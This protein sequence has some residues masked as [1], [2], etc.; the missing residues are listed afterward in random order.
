MKEGRKT[1]Y[2]WLIVLYGA[3][4]MS[5]LHYTCFNSF[6]LFV[7]PV[8]EGL[9]IS[10][11]AFSLTMTVGSIASVIASPLTGD[12]LAYKNVKKY[13]FFGILI[14]G[15]SVFLEGFASSVYQLYFLTLVL[16]LASNFALALPF[17]IL[18]L[19]WFRGRSS[20]AIS[21]IFVGVSLGGL[22][23]S[24]PITALI[25][26]EG[27]R[28]AYR[29]IGLVI[30][31]IVAP[32]C[33]LIV[34]N[35]PEGEEKSVENAAHRASKSQKPKFDKALYKEKRFW[36]LTAGL[37]FN[38]FA[39]VALYHIPA[40]IQSLG[41]TAAFAA[42]MVSFYSFINI[43]SKVGMGMLVDKHGLKAG[44]LGGVV[45]TLGCYVFM[46][47]ASGIP[48]VP[49]I[50]VFSFLFGIGLATQSIFMPSLVSG[51]YGQEKYST[52]YGRI[53]VFTLMA[54]ARSNPIISSVYEVTKSYR[55]AWLICIVI[56]LLCGICLLMACRERSDPGQK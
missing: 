23:W 12:L 17:S 53:S 29:V 14:S 7:V 55:M 34:R 16:Q 11:A 9:G 30:M 39:C 54:S 37:F 41:Y 48:S 26:A 46:F 20:F 24:S 40:F 31:L 42:M 22:F 56:A 38:S 6:G 5:T 36:L 15:I 43:F 44:G 47:I 51:V 45:G 21:I 3:L 10:R 18:M 1:Y 4:V 2:G 33:L 25:E 49:M 27:W 28:M 50:A 19:R 13:M 32:L 52:I 8:T 35:Y